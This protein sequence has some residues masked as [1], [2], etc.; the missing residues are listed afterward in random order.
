[1]G[2]CIVYYP[3]VLDETDY[4][5][6]ASYGCVDGLWA[7]QVRAAEA[8]NGFELRLIVPSKRS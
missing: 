3:L 4:P 7:S 5:L 2:P 6:R 1:M 8:G